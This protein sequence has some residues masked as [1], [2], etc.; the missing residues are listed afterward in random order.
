MITLNVH[1]YGFHL[2]E[3]GLVKTETCSQETNVF[4]LLDWLTVYRSITLV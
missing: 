4:Y 1:L 2:P 3:H